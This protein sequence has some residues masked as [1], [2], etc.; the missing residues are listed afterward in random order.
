[1]PAPAICAVSGVVYGPSA[2][3]LE[4]VNVKVY[5]TSAFTDNSGNYIP[6]GVLAST[7]TDENGEWTL[8][9]IRTAN[10]G[11]S[12]TFQFEYPLG[13]QQSRSVKYA[14]IIPEQASAD[15][16]DLVDLST[17][18]S[19]I[20]SNVTTDSLPEGVVNLYFTV[21]RARAALSFTAPIDETAGVVS[22]PAASATEDG[23]L[24][25]EDWAQFNAAAAPP[26]TSVNGFIGDVVLDI[27]DV[28]PTQT[29]NAGKFLST[30]GTNA[31]WQDVPASDVTSV[32]GQTGT[33][34]LDI[35]DVAPAQTGNA[36][37][38]LT[39]DGTNASWQDAGA[40]AVDSVNGQTGVV[41]LDTGDI[42]ESGNLYFTDGRAQTAAVLN[43]LAGSETTQA[44]SVS[45]VNTALAAKQATGNYITALTGDVTA[46]GP[47]S[48]AATLATVNS[49]VGSFTNASITVNAKG[50]ITAASSGSAGSS[51]Y[52]SSQELTNLGLAAS[53]SGNALTIALKQKDGSTNPASGSGAVKIGFR[54]ST[55]GTGQY[56]QRSVTGALSITVSSGSTLGSTNGNPNW[57]YVYAIDNAGTVELAVSALKRID[58]GSLVTTTAEGGAGAADSKTT[59]Y[60]TTA[61]SNVAVRLIGRVKSTQATAGTWA[62]TPSEVSL[63]PFDEQAPYHAIT[64]W[65]G[66]GHGSTN[67][68]IRRFASTIT[69]GTAI[70]YAS[71]ATNGDSFT[72]NEDGIY[73]I[74]YTDWS[75]AAAEPHG[76][77]VDSTQLTTSVYTINVSSAFPYNGRLKCAYSA[78]GLPSDV[79]WTGPLVAGQVIRAHDAG[80]GSMV[81]SDLAVQFWI[82]K[83][84]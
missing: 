53:V 20:A 5:V 80:S 12:V 46:S 16:A 34:V 81:N 45:A 44:P 77:S 22:M 65:S 82:A 18:A 78:T 28:A 57:V 7:Q 62:T 3:P 58:E 10:L 38:V 2:L 35:D 70:T 47:G 83:V 36:G 72:I 67:N 79:A 14:A 27:D 29:G 1:M 66:A 24:T 11:R 13:N 42:A 56:V 39:T 25:K 61:R 30:D 48:A 6:E 32:N 41:V 50:L 76:I 63:V 19:I 15:F 26:V 4:G 33:V 21:A 64:A 49:N 54:D 75:S 60:S 40:G 74:S 71:N 84:G 68:A 43:T 23:Y 51:G 17:G 59:I 52:D 55:A 8:D 73:S 37:K 69:V 31:T 9:V